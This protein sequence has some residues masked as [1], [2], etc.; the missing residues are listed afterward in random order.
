[1]NID[2]PTTPKFR[3]EFFYLETAGILNRR[4]ILRFKTL[5]E[6]IDFAETFKAKAEGYQIETD[7]QIK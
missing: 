7:Y 1:M 6:A 3:I 4:F 2:S 5:A